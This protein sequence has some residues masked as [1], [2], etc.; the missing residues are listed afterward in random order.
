MVPE[1]EKNGPFNNTSG[2]LDKEEWNWILSSKQTKTSRAG[3]E[4]PERLG[5]NTE[6]KWYGVDLGN[7]C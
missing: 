1:C 4:T 3:P 7:E 2:K 5:E 6:G